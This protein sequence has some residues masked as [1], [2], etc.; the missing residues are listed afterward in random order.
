MDFFVLGK[1]PPRKIASSPNSN[2]NP[3]PN[4]DPDRRAIFLGANS[5]ETGFFGLND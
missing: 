4:P 5:P 1:L 2:A 3:K